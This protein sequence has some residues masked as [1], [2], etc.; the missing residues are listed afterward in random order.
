M[1]YFE[2]LTRGFWIPFIAI[3]AVAIAIYN[4]GVSYY[5]RINL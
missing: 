3:G 5:W 2:K 4:L 1:V